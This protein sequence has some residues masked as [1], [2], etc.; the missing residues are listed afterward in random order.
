MG[1]KKGA[2]IV[3]FVNLIALLKANQIARITKYFKMGVINVWNQ[4]MPRKL[5]RDF[6]V[7]YTNDLLN[8]WTINK[9]FAWT[10]TF[11]K[12]GFDECFLKSV[13]SL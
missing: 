3:Q 7:S 11:K 13:I 2:K 10:L 12:Q 4:V 9:H 1:I 6:Y 8:L 5:I